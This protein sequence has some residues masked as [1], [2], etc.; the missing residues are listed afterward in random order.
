MRQNYIKSIRRISSKGNCY[1]QHL[2]LCVTLM[3]HFLKIEQLKLWILTIL[4][5]IFLRRS[6]KKSIETIYI[7]LFYIYKN[8]NAGTRNYNKAYITNFLL[9]GKTPSCNN[10][11]SRSSNSNG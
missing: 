2:K 6:F 1:G 3:Y 7:R 5:T 8:K 4:H 11:S 10:S 9:I